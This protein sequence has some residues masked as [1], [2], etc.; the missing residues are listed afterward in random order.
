MNPM[1]PPTQDTAS[2][3]V[4]VATSAATGAALA[5]LVAFWEAV[6]MPDFRTLALVGAG[7]AGVGALIGR[8]LR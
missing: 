6:M 2:L 8:A 3:A 1:M 4:L 5:I 7:G